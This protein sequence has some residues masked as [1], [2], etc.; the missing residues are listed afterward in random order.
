L[1]STQLITK[2]FAGEG[3]IAYP[4]ALRSSSQSSDKRKDTHEKG[5]KY[6]HPS[7]SK[8]NKKL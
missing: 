5:G 6:S 3:E 4:Y 2:L 7:K 1:L 8:R